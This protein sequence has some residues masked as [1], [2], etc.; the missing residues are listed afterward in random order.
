MTNLIEPALAFIEGL[1]L[2]VS[3]CIL[4]VLPLVLGASVDG[5]RRRPFGIIIGFVLSFSLF[6][7]ASR[8]LINAFGI[9]AESIK[10]VSLVLLALFGAILIS[11]KLSTK[12]STLTQGAAN[13]GGKVSSIGKDG[14]FSGVV[15]GGLIGLIWT[16]CAG[17]ILAAVLVQVIR[18][19]TNLQSLIIIIP[20]ALGASIPMFIIALTGRTMIKKM[21]FFTKHAESIRKVFGILIILSVAYIAFDAKAQSLLS[22]SVTDKPNIQALSLQNALEKSYQAPELSGITSWL[23][24]EPLTLSQLKGKVVLIDFWTYSCINCVR[25]LPHVTAWDKKYRDKGL[26]I[27]GVHAPEF[28]FEKEINNVKAALVAHGIQYPVALDNE[29]DTWTAYN[30][31]FWPAHYLIDQKGQVVYTHFG[32]GNYDITE[33]NIRFLLGLDQQSNIKSDK[34]SFTTKAQT[35]ETYLGYSRVENFSGAETVQKETVQDYNVPSTLPI[36][37]WALS[38]R[39]KID[40]EKIVAQEKGA[41][42]KINFNAKSVYLVLGNANA[43]K[44]PI[45]VTVTQQG[46]PNNTKQIEITS[47]TLYTLMQLDKVENGILQITTDQAG[48]EAYAFTFGS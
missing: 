16:P 31:R 12:F 30:N 43:D 35:P 45:S 14:F 5:G 38:G 47:H 18:Q 33:N 2:I 7:L 32:E 20:F 37:H 29:F 39:W 22:N 17:P 19:E 27:I 41:A 3:P 10:E 15:I 48:L 8:Q 24:T 46:K 36:D 21:S 11:E 9:D 25:T 1:A 44:K 28:A 23:N 13:L 6:A 42:I 40:A 26:V 4:P 34:Q